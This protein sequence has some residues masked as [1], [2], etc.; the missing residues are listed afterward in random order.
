VGQGFVVVGDDPDLQ[1]LAIFT[2]FLEGGETAAQLDDEVIVVA[3]QLE[4]ERLGH[5]LVP[6]AR[7]VDHR[8]G[9]PVA[10]VGLRKT[11]GVGQRGQLVQQVHVV[12]RGTAVAKELH[13]AADGVAALDAPE[14]AVERP[15]IGRDALAQAP[16]MFRPPT[17]RTTSTLPV[18]TATSFSRTS[19][20]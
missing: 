10:A 5:A 16:A 6:D 13:G 8:A 20:P 7:H 12:H 3:G 1:I 4:G 11:P 15:A 2:P 9:L 17:K 14:L 18:P 19:R